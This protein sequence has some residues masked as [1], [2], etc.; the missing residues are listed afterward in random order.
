MIFQ[1]SLY[2]RIGGDF[3]YGE[4]EN[5]EITK[6]KA[7]K[8]DFGLESKISSLGKSTVTLNSNYIIL[9]YNNETNTPLAFEMLESLQPGN[10]ITWNINLQRNIS[11]NMQL[12]LRYNGRQSPGTKT[13]HVG[14]IQLRAYF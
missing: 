11:G 3:A 5:N 4:K 2:F 13:I 12:N 7:T 9:K 1:P 8:K 14:S 6:E 10:N